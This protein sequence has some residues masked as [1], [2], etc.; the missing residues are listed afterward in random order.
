M[1]AVKIESEYA[2]LAE[3]LTLKLA[4]ESLAPAGVRNCKVQA[5]GVNIMPI[6]SGRVVTQGIFI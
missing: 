2:R 1:E 5:V 3:P 4:P 6:F